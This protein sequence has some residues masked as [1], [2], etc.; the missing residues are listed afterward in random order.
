MTDKN[1]LTQFEWQRVQISKRGMIPYW[2]EL[3]WQTKKEE[4]KQE[5]TF[6]L[7]EKEYYKFSWKARPD[8]SPNDFLKYAKE[9]FKDIANIEGGKITSTWDTKEVYE[10]QLINYAGHKEIPTESDKTIGTVSLQ[11][12][13]E[14]FGYDRKDVFIPGNMGIVFGSKFAQPQKVYKLLQETGLVVPDESLIT[15]LEQ[16]LSNYMPL[17]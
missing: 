5:L 12:G 6:L 8:F 7:A 3:L 10:I 9:H 11:S 14:L 17:S 16:K 13:N 4:P 15:E 2:V 1:N